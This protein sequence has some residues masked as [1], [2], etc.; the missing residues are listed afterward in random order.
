MLQNFFPR[1]PW[2]PLGPLGAPWGPLGPIGAHWGPWGP[3]GPI[4]GPI[5]DF[6]L[7]FEISTQKKKKNW[8]NF[9]DFS[10]NFRFF[11]NFGAHW[12]PMGPQWAPMGPN[13]PQ[14]GPNGPQCLKT[15]GK[16][17][18]F[19]S[20]WPKPKETLGFAIFATCACRGRG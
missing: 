3:W 9:H 16:I 5:R 15:Q 2:G 20:R 12:A 13:G 10:L 1:G 8:T 18:F 11:R 19:A 17:L 6:E 14:W 7:R 4:W